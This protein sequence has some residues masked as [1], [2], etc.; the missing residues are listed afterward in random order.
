MKA[1]LMPDS[2]DNRA[3]QYEFAWKSL[4]DETA[5]EK[6][7]CHARCWLTY[8]CLDGEI[9]PEDWPAWTLRRTTHTRLL[10]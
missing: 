10:A 8:R 6:D 9:K 7:R 3:E 1:N 2:T 5:P 4:L